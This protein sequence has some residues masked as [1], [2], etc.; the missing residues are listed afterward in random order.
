M[1]ILDFSMRFRRFSSYKESKG[2]HPKRN[3]FL[4]FGEMSNFF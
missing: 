1:K 4:F 2:P 3:D